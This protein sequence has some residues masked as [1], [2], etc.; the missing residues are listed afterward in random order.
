MRKKVTIALLIYL[1]IAASAVAQS[2]NAGF[3]FNPGITVGTEYL[4]PAAISDSSDFGSTKYN[5]Q[6]SQPLKTKIGIKALSLK[7]FSFKKLDAKASQLFLN[8]SFGVVQPT[9]T[10]NN[11]FE[12]IYKASIGLTAITASIRKGIWIYSANVSVAENSSTFGGDITPNARGYVANIKLKNLNTF[13]FYGG[14]LLLNQGKLIPFPVLGLRTNLGKHLKTEVILPLHVKFNYAFNKKV[15]LDM[16]AHFNG[17]NTIYRQG[18]AYGNNDATLNFRQL[19]TYLA[20][21]AKLGTHYK[22]KIEGGY[23]SLQQVYS[24]SAETSTEVDPAPYVG[25]SFNYSFGKSV[26]G[27][28]MNRAE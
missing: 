26:F 10:D 12:N 1:G 7:D 17:I 8:Y 27:N 19:K 16:V 22:I 13:Y 14:G 24:W 5:V 3:L 4:M 15:D 28:F 6:F 20:L 25:I 18:S 23:S 2:F 9:I 21:N 11:N